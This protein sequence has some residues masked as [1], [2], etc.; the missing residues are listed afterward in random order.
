MLCERSLTWHLTL[1]PGFLTPGF[2]SA[3]SFDIEPANTQLWWHYSYQNRLSENWSF[4]TGVC[5]SALLTG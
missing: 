1:T 3:Q 4:T 2:P 5:C